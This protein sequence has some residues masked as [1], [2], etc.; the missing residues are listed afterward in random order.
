M[1]LREKGYENYGFSGKKE[2]REL[3]EHCRDLNHDELQL[4]KKAAMCANPALA[5][6]LVESLVGGVSYQR[7]MLMVDIPA[8][9]KDFYAYRRKT[10]GVFKKFIEESCDL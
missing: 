10:L 2:A 1:R 9:E 3:L 8:G 7:L 6:A 5:A 4:L